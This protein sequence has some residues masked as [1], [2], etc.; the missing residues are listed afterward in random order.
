MTHAEPPLE[1]RRTPLLHKLLLALGSAVLA[2][3]GLEVGLRLIGPIGPEF[4]LDVETSEMPPELFHPD[5]E[6]GFRPMPDVEGVYTTVEFSNVVRTNH[7]GLRGDQ[8]TP[9]P[10]GGRRVLAIGD[11]FTFGAQVKEEETFA[12]RLGPLLTERLGKSVEV[13]NGGVD[14][15]GTYDQ[16]AILKQLK[17]PLEADTALMAYYLGNDPLDNEIAATGAAPPLAS[18][19]QEAAEALTE[20][21]RR[22]RKLA[23]WSRIYAYFLATSLLSYGE[24]DFRV[25]MQKDAVRIFADPAV[26]ER[27]M[28]YTEEALVLYGESCERERL[29]CF[30]VLIPPLFAVS[31]RRANATFRAF[32]MDPAAADVDAV[33]AAVLAA[34]PPSLNVLDLTPSIRAGA[35]DEELYYRFD[36]HWNPEG[37]RVAAEAM[38]E[39]MASR[40]G[41]APGR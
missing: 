24:Q 29:T 40:M 5:P 20:R 26:R 18:M 25:A 32:G 11:S 38:A 41:Q 31:E 12:A 22:N 7:Y 2:V 27:L 6:S 28:P 23:S 39:F 15:T 37:H 3:V 33:A 21:G 9:R 35:E 8:I 34:A 17:V 10:R 13:L 19:T 14:G 16:L 36:A 4:V 1:R 30:L